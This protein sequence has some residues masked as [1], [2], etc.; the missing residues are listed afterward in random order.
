MV[1]AS[2]TVMRHLHFLQIL[3][4][5]I[6]TEMVFLMVRKLMA[7]METPHRLLIH[8]ITIQMMTPLTM[9]MRMRMVMG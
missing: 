7:S 8:V 1:M 5:Q 4:I 3:Q 6:P 2:M 9:V